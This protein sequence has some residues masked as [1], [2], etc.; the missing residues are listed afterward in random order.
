[1]EDLPPTVSPAA[2]RPAPP[3]PPPSPP[4]A[5]AGGGGL[6]RDPDPGASALIDEARPVGLARLTV[7]AIAAT[8]IGGGIWAGL[9]VVPLR[10]TVPGRVL[11][12]PAPVAVTV[13]EGGLIARVEAHDGET[14]AAEQVLL[15]LDPGPALAGL[16]QARAHLATV[17][18]RAARLKA[19][20]E[21]RP[22]D[23]TA[24]PT[25]P[26]SPAEAN[27]GPEARR[28]AVAEAAAA[29]EIEQARAVLRRIERDDATLRAELEAA[30]QTLRQREQQHER[31]LVSRARVAQAERDVAQLEALR[32]RVQ[33][34]AQAARDALT[35]AG[36]R[37]EAARSGARKQAM[38]ELALTLDEAARAREA[39]ALFERRGQ[40]LEVRAPAAGLVRGLAVHPAGT[41][42]APGDT[43][44]ELLP[45]AAAREIEI[46][47]P[48]AEG[49]RVHPGQP[50]WVG[51]GGVPTQAGRVDWVAEPAVGEGSGRPERQGRVVLPAAAGAEPAA[52]LPDQ[53]VSV[54]IVVGERP[55]LR[56]LLAPLLRRLGAAPE[57]AA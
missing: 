14:V 18:A 13:A 36:E 6:W 38:D 27:P 12:P 25:E 15:R 53:T 44:A 45:P 56:A 7:L 49:G 34:E 33:T 42:L 4:G 24:A 17:E 55:L 35:A 46:R 10:V 52:L 39:V 51:G 50:A 16:A 2:P 47:L 57:D 3:S 1:M 19:L 41:A 5:A 40:R 9:A 54:S 21:G 30:R 22:A 48:L 23:L 29:A 43:V 20:A 8:L 26:L 37:L 32:G 28:D 11:P 31:L